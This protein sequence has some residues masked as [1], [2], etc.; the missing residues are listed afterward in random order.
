MSIIKDIPVK[1][2]PFS[3]SELLIKASTNV[4]WSHEY[5]KILDI[6]QKG[7]TGK[8]VKVAVLDTGVQLDHFLFEKAVADG[9]LK[10][11]DTTGGDGLDRQGHGSWCV[12]RYIADDPQ[13][14]G[15]S[16]DVDMISIK[17]LG[18]GGS[19]K[20]SDVIRGF[21]L[22]I[23]EDVDIIST[24]LGWTGRYT[25]FDAVVKKAN[26][27]G[28]LMVSA[29]GNDG[30]LEDIDY[31]GLYADI[32]AIGSHGKTGV[33]SSFSD[34]GVDLDLYG[35]GESVKGAWRDSKIT[36]SRG[37]S[38]ATPSVGALIALLLQRLKEEYGTIDRQLLKQLAK[39][40]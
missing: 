24:S 10:A 32:F 31:P 14:I 16:P 25:P 28:I 9:R 15:F 27:K 19:G 35:S 30:K 5:Y 13:L 12:S 22:A 4:D 8:N 39:C 6:H 17:V 21:E 11:F 37:T 18:D 38:M 34:W 20:L 40:Q 26:D 1:L 36:L 33:K 29:A 7:Y 23:A 2:H 3:H